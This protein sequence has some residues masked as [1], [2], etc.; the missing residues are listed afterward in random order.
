MQDVQNMPNPDVNSTVRDDDFGNHSDVN[1]ENPNSDVE[2]PTDDI[3]VPPGSE[4]GVPIKE[5]P[6]DDGTEEPKRIA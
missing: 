2:Q 5:P 4:S 1:R 6:A 3:P